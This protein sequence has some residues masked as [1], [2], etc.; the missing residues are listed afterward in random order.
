MTRTERLAPSHSRCLCQGSLFPSIPEQFVTE[1]Y[2]SADEMGSW[3]RRGWLSFDPPAIAEYDD[4]ERV[5]VQFIKGLARSGLSD[6][7]IDRIVSGLAKPYCYDPSTTFYSFVEN[8]WISLPPEA[9]Q[10]D[11]TIEYLGELIETQ[12]WNSLR[13]LQGKISRALED[14]EDAK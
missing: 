2:V 1:M 11:V 3:H 12:D 7:M 14:A 9:D 13:Q 4:K 10:A 5:E 6:L 8:R